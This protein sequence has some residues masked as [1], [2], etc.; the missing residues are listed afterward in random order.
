[1]DKN[2][3]KAFENVFRGPS[4]L[5]LKRLRFY[6]PLINPLKDV[7]GEC[8]VVDLGCGRGEWLQLISEAGF[9]GH[10]VD[11][12]EAMLETCITKGLSVIKGDVLDF[13]K[14][15]PD[16]SQAIVSAFHV[17]EHLEFDKLFH[18]VKEAWRVLKPAGMLI[19]ETPNPQNIL[20]GSI[21]FYI[22]PTHLR[23]IPHE[24]LRFLAEYNGFERIKIFFLQED[25]TLMEK[26][27]ISILD[28]LG[29]ASPDY[30]M[31][32]QKS[33]PAEY[34][35]LFDPIFKDDKNGL[36]IYDLSQKYDKYHGS[37][38]S[39]WREALSRL[40]TLIS[41]NATLKEKLHQISIDKETLLEQLKKNESLL[42]SYQ[43]T[44]DQLQKSHD[45]LSCQ[46]QSI[47][48]ENA[49][50]KE[51]LH[52]INAQMENLLLELGLLKKQLDAVYS[53]YSWK[54][55]YPLR[56]GLTALRSLIEI[57]PGLIINVRRL[58]LKP[59]HYILANMIRF[60][61]NRPN[62][63]R[64]FHECLVKFP[65]LYWK[66]YRFACDKG[67]VKPYVSTT[68]NEIH[69]SSISSSTQLSVKVLKMYQE[70]LRAVEDC[71]KGLK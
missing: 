19:I 23:P 26:T 18:V 21:Y 70:L 50:L 71:K 62:V 43:L 31:V 8:S 36:T 65:R 64:N 53:S 40:E 54:I 39:I 30:S 63:R 58:L 67:I 51:K 68:S 4:E 41:E 45:E 14:S 47:S 24:L 12:D 56:L 28:V 55:T 20:M 25:K 59:I 15:L 29:G 32:A 1:M 27:S 48:S 11:I 46:V 16:E 34:R 52:Q 60:V 22:D 35:H 13:L 69:L 33:C 44:V 2:F 57:L 37:F 3:Y 17:V 49:T 5:V 6:I 66:L 9:K 38:E 61:L 10:G 7:Y 42:H